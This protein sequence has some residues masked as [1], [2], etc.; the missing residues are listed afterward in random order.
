MLLLLPM[1]EIETETLIEERGNYRPRRHRR[2][3][4][5]AGNPEGCGR[6]AGFD[7]EPKSKSSES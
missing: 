3:Q 2:L 6:K 5:E 1:Q 4:S 7:V